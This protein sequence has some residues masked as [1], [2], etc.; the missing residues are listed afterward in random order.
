MNAVAII[1]FNART[2]T[3]QWSLRSAITRWIALIILMRKYLTG[4]QS[5]LKLELCYKYAELALFCLQA[6]MY[7]INW[8]FFKVQYIVYSSNSS[9]LKWQIILEKIC[10]FFKGLR[11]RVFSRTVWFSWWRIINTDSRICTFFIVWI[12][13]ELRYFIAGV[14]TSSFPSATTRI[15]ETQHVK[16]YLFTPMPQFWITATFRM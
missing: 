5:L 2:G 16:V 6:E 3:A 8:R 12:I 1:L 14:L 4:T 10:A 11:V 13:I 9:S 15:T 7:V